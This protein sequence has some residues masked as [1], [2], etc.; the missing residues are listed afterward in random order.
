M[1]HPGPA[2]GWS[3]E[4][5]DLDAYLARTGMDGALP[6]TVETLRGL[7]RAHTLAIPFENIE[8]VLG[9][10][11]LLDVERLQD[12]MVRRR[13]GGYCYEHTIL[14]AAA[15]ERLGFGVT[16]LASRVRLGTGLLRPATHA[17]LRVETAETAGDGRAWI[18]DVGFGSGQLEPIE[19]ADGAETAGDGPPFRLRRERS[20]GGADEW[21]L[22]ARERDGWLDL[23]GFTLDPRYAADY[24]VI[25]HY[26]STHPRS[27][28][29]GRLRVQR[30][31][32]DAR[33]VL[34]DTTLKI[35]RPDGTGERE[36]RLEPHEVAEALADLFGIVLDE[37]DS[38]RLAAV[39]DGERAKA[40]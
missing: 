7:Q 27:P 38:A 5:L 19:L 10:P 33:Y 6:P 29:V 35:S 20:P 22:Y 11:I 1:A 30:G 25:N 15:L 39:L 31:Q 21:V 26:I 18:C 12:K 34:D 14:F 16:G 4:L 3:G 23:H 13:R 2:Y 8:I 17:L 32:V 28:F 36:R 40:G 9:R 24:T 37:D